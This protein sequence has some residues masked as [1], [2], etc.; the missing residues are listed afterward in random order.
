MRIFIFIFLIVAA[1]QLQAQDEVATTLVKL[2]QPVPEFSF[3][4]ETG[5][6]I[7]ISDYK[8]K[9]VLIT[10]FATW[11]G[12]CRKEL[13]LVQSDIY[14]EYKDNPNFKLLIFGREHNLQ[15]VSDFKKSQGFS[16]PFYADKERL[17]YSLFASKYIPRNFLINAE[18]KI[19][20]SET[21]FDID[22]F[23]KLK[24]L[25]QENINQ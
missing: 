21:G 3:K 11:C 16:M 19:I 8:G 1:F 12:P 10:F 4:D 9:T 7:S 2:N 5:K 22:T 18:G 20:F 6:T 13:P 25:I 15:E 14:N 17:V 24:K 23:D